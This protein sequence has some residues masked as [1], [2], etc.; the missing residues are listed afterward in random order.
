VIGALKVDAAIRARS[1]VALL[2]S[3]DGAADGVKKLDRLA[4]GVYGEH[5]ASIVRINLF[6]SR[7]LDLALGRSNVIHAALNAGPASTAFL[8]KV[9]RLTD[10]RASETFPAAAPAEADEGLATSA[11]AEQSDIQ[12]GVTGFTHERNEQ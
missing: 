5:D 11:T 9:A 6:S 12:A 7:Q 1:V 3:T 8:V 10:Y 4:K 2:S